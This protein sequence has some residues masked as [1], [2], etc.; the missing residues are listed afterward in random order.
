M[1]LF[2]LLVVCCSCGPCIL[3][4]QI[5]EP[6][7]STGCAGVGQNV[8]I[9]VLEMLRNFSTHEISI[10]PLH[11]LAS[12]TSHTAKKTSFFPGLPMSNFGF[13]LGHLQMEYELTH[14]VRG[15]VTT[16]IPPTPHPLVNWESLQSEPS[17]RAFNAKHA[18]ASKPETLNREIW[19]QKAHPVTKVP[20]TAWSPFFL[21]PGQQDKGNLVT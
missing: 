12:R 4:I 1:P 7:V 19:T 8:C 15:E 16:L 5:P 3:Y 13:Y 17:S 18:Q 10:H 14:S 6:V 2:S 20:R 9:Q 11:S 21:P